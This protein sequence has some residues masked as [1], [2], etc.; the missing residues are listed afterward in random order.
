MKIISLIPAR[1][2]SKGL[3]HKNIKK[4]GRHSLIGLAIRC[5]KNSKFINK[6]ILSTD[7]NL[8]ASIG[9]KYGAEVPYLRPKKIST[10]NIKDISV[11]NHMIKELNLGN[12]KN[13]EYII[14]YLRPTSP[15]RTP[16]IIDAA[17]ENFLKNY[18]RYDSLR[19]VSEMSESA[20]K[21]FVI[22]DKNLRSLENEKHYLE[23]S[24]LP[25]QR[26]KKTY[27][28]NGLIDIYKLSFVLKKKKLHGSNVYPYITSQFPEIDN[29]ND[30][31]YAKYFFKIKKTL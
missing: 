20:F 12:E 29:L 21:A 7:S 13:K 30:F 17:I 8:Y 2:G 27:T 28:G 4:I 26:V 25:R 31:N 1:S 11:V 15:F 24:N 6:T 22:K 3:K 23:S 10:S 5:S 14:V 9:K 16:K 18:K 19:S